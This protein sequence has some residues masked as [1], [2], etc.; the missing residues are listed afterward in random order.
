MNL[1]AL[2][3]GLLSGVRP[4]SSLGAV[5]VLLKAP[6]PGRLL[7]VFTAAGLAWTMTVGLVV[8]GVFHGAD[9]AV[10]RSTFTAVLDVALGAAALGF[11]C[12]LQ[13]GWVK[14]TR[15]DGSSPSATSG[16]SRLGRALR[17]PST[18]HV[19]L[20]G[21]GTHLPG[22]VYLAALNA[23]ASGEPSAAD[24]VLQVAVYNALWFLVPIASLVLTVTRPGAARA[25]LDAATAWVRR[26]E[27]AVLTTGSFLIGGYL[28]AKG[29]ERLLT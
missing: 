21:M 18:G 19:V 24:A 7:L 26:H 1:E 17:D 5:L 16:G 13:M 29:A 15:R 23:I 6:R 20:V 4:G 9:V 8:V 3:L 27:H 28:L 11:A 25:Y 12:G 14:P 10:G 22:L 2:L